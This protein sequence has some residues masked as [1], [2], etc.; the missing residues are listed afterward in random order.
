MKYIRLENNVVIEYPFSLNSLRT[1]FPKVS[2]PRNYAE[3]AIA[4]LGVYPVSEVPSPAYNPATQT[5]VEST[6]IIVNGVWTQ[7][8]VTRNKTAQEIKDFTV[9]QRSAT[10]MSRVKSML[11]IPAVKQIKTLPNAQAYVDA[12]VTDL[13]TAK[14]LLARLTFIVANIGRHMSDQ[15]D[16]LFPDDE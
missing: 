14:I 1:L 6:P 11:N 12:N 7:Q 10:A 3:T 15:D 5:V 8:W 9:S 16:D 2:L 4:T 13:A